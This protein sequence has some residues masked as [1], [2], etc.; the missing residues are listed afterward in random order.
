M[1]T[2]DCNVMVKEE[3]ELSVFNNSNLSGA[4]TLKR[5]PNEA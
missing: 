3:T 2:D 5:G 4:A 1:K